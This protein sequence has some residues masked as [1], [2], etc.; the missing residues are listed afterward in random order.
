MISAVILTWN[1]ASYIE[2]S[3][4]SL[5]EDAYRS[6]VGLEI[7][8]VD[9]GSDDGTLEILSKLAQDIPELRILPLERNLGTTKSRNIAVKKS[10]GDYVLIADSDTE[11]LPGAISA[12]YKTLK[13]N[14]RAGIAAP[15]L[16][17]PDG[18]VQPSCKRFPNIVLK[19]CKFIPIS[20]LKSFGEK[21]E[22][23]PQEVYAKPF[24]KT[25]AVDHCISAFWLVRREAIDLV[26][27]LD[28]RISYAPEDVDYCLRMWLS[29]WEVLYV[30]LAEVI[31]HTQRLS[32]KR[33]SVAWV[34]MKGLL[35]FFRKH[36]YCLSR[37]ALY[38]RIIRAASL[39]NI[40][41]PIG[42]ETTK[43]LL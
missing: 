22:L 36:G 35:Y 21:M 3:L 15:R 32:Y 39:Y 33:L 2:R 19:A 16:L 4:R 18:N 7:F 6:A 5:V 9:G 25:V 14:P 1:S 28:E 40:N 38:R 37:K 12:L 23:Y 24:R 29:G 43:R 20:F 27:L 41:F 31:H 30:P 13:N 42:L 8:V 17:Y 26:G 10:R 34:H 11:V